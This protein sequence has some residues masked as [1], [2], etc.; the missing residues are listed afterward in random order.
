MWLVGGRTDKH[1]NADTGPLLLEKLAC[2]NVTLE[3]T[4]LGDEDRLIRGCVYRHNDLTSFR[5]AYWE[6]LG[7]HERVR[8][9]RSWADSDSGNQLICV[10]RTTIGGW[11]V[12]FPWSC[13]ASAKKRKS[14]R[15]LEAQ[16][17]DADFL[18][19]STTPELESERFAT[20]MRANLIFYA[21]SGNPF[22]KGPL[23]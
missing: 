4:Y 10:Y 14:L 16:K 18:K 7:P 2:L 1:G 8:S 12:I 6:T 20:N 22:E 19:W 11:N 9:C 5:P 23:N 17:S 13:P 15:N 21:D 3:L